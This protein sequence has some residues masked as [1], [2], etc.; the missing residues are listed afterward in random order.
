M[1]APPLAQRLDIADQVV[2]GARQREVRH[3]SVRM[4]QENAQLIGSRA[5][6]YNQLEAWRALWGGT[7]RITANNVAIGAPLPRDLHALAGIGVGG[8]RGEAGNH[9]P[10][11]QRY[12]R[13]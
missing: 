10:A 7:V 2:D 5:T 1:K 12:R 8:G 6:A 4:R 11:D 3:R 13:F 9:R